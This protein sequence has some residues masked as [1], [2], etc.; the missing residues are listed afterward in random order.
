MRVNMLYI[1][2]EYEYIGYTIY[3][4]IYVRLSK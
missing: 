2:F 3:F 4:L 1:F